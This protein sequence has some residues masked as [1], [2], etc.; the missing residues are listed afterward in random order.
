M[1]T[2]T[3]TPQQWA[4]NSKIPFRVME[5]EAD[6]HVEMARLMAD[7]L[8]KNNAVKLVGILEVEKVE[9]SNLED[10]EPKEIYKNIDMKKY[11]F[12]IIK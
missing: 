2:Y 11:T 8:K 1:N 9:Y 10:Q 3:C 7:V 5:K 6:M 12:S 4:E